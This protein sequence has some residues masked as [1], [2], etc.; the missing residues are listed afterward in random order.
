MLDLQSPLS[1]SLS[2]LNITLLLEPLASGEIS[3]SVF[4]FPECKVLAPTREDAIA[5]L[6]ALILQR[7]NKMEAISW[8]VPLPT[9]E[10]QWMK[11]AGIFQGDADFTAVVDSIQSERSNEDNSEVDPSYYQ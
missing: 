8:K 4:E 11:F 7:L 9:D 6:Q 5:Q 3:A 2:Q 1:E 10:P